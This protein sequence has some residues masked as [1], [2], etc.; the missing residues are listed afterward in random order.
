MKQYIGDPT[1]MVVH[2]MLAKTP[3]C[4]VDKIPKETRKEWDALY[5]ATK[6]GFQKCPNCIGD[7]IW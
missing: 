5:E 2:N 1:R 3:E 6:A 4:Y 7:R